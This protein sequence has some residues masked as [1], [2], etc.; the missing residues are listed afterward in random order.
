MF[1]PFQAYHVQFRNHNTVETGGRALKCLVFTKLIV[2]DKYPSIISFTYP[3]KFIFPLV[4]RSSTT[5]T[6][7]LIP[8]PIPILIP[9]PQFDNLLC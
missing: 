6:S 3:P 8:I 1:V 2:L 5:S 9:S 4:R 7:I